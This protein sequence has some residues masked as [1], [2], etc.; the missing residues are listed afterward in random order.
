MDRYLKEEC[1]ETVEG[2]LTGNRRR[3]RE[4]PLKG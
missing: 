4:R 3:S 2:V 1:R